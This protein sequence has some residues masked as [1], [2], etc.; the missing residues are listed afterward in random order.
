MWHALVN[1]RWTLVDHVDRDGRRY[2][3]ARKNDP[4]VA[5]HHA[6]TR[7]E[8]QVIGFAAFGHSNKLIAYELGLSVSSV[9]AYLEIAMEKLGVATRAELIVAARAFGVDAR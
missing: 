6:L 5:R 2:F 7:R 1:G 3:V 8:R 9:A 4:E